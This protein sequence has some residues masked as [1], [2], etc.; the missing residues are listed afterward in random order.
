MSEPAV[1][2]YTLGQ[3]GLLAVL[4]RDYALIII[5]YPQYYVIRYLGI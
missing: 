1:G 4:K 5:S 3:F 2:T